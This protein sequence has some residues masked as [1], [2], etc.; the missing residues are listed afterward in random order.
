[1]KVIVVGGGASGLVS[2]IFASMNGNEVVILERNSF[3]GKKILV[4][5]NGKCNY[6]N[7][8][9]DL[10]HYH[11]SNPEI[12]DKIITTEIKDK[13]LAFFDMLGIIPKI[14]NGYYYPYS[15]QATSIQ[16]SLILQVQ[17]LGAKIENNVYVKSI[18][19]KQNQY[20]IQTDNGDFFADKVIIATGSK[21]S[22]KTGS[23]GNGYD[24][25]TS[26]GHSII[27]PLPALVQ[28]IGEGNY[29]KEWTGIRQDVCVR[30]IEDGIFIKEEI[31]EISLTD[32]GLSG[33]CVMQLSGIIAK[34]LEVGKSEC[35]LINFVPWLTSNESEFIEWMD[36]R[37]TKVKN[38]NVRQLLDGILNYKL[39]NL[40]VKKSKIDENG[41]WQD[42]DINSKL[43]LAKNIVSF[44]QKIVSTHTFDKAQVC[45]GGVPLTEI[46]SYTMESLKSKGL[47]IVGELLDV[48]GDCGGYNLG[49]AWISGILAG[50][51]IIK[52]ELK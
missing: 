9:Q 44:E 36:I 18:I 47:Y 21:A 25:I 14:K 3:C 29:F 33:I 49:F 15:N 37:N 6:W 52:G 1:M 31:G 38:R 50:T 19:K 5:G 26:L 22:P 41:R 4:T 12:L 24:L 30:L 2:A 35:V 8:D 45:S 16:T 34:G 23:D 48:D 20:I 39:V 10:N 40:I 43:L 28:L 13:V 11:S 51:S 46:N 7:C 17:L 32:Y 27:K 42:L